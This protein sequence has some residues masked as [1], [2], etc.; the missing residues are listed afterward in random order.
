MVRVIC[1]QNCRARE[2][3]IFMPVFPIW[4]QLECV[5][6]GEVTSPPSS[7]MSSYESAY[8][9][10]FFCLPD[11]YVINVP[12]RG[13]D[14]LASNTS[15]HILTGPFLTVLPRFPN[16]LSKMKSNHPLNSEFF[17]F[18]GSLPS[19]WLRVNI[20]FSTSPWKCHDLKTCY[21]GTRQI[22]FFS[23]QM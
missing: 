12:E 5:C 21:Q 22:L 14:Q 11:A 23:L 3:C 9:Q 18:R 16:L 20:H 4:E 19:Q 13:R 8:V 17:L 1:R 7:F 15:F 10:P 6:C 2:P